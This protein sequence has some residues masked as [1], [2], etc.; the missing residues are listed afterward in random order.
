MART[1]P[2]AP[3]LRIA[4]GMSQGGRSYQEDNLQTQRLAAADEAVLLALADGMGGHAGGAAAS[5]LA[6]ERFQAVAGGAA[7]AS[8][9]TILSAD[10]LFEG[11]KAAN[12]AIGAKVAKGEGPAGMGCTLV[13]VRVD[14]RGLRWISVGDSLLWVWSPTRGLRRLNAD[15]SMAPLIDKMVSQGMISAADAEADPQRHALRS[16]LTGEDITLI[17]ENACDWGDDRV[18]LV[19]SDGVLTLDAPK[20]A[21]LC[22]A[23]ASDP[24]ALVDALLAA[25]A[26][27]GDPDQD[28]TS[29]IALVRGEGAAARSSRTHRIEGAERAGPNIPRRIAVA[30]VVLAAVVAAALAG[31][32]VMRGLHPQGPA[33]AP[34]P[35]ASFPP[36][37]PL[38][39]SPGTPAN[40]TA[41]PPSRD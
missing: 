18:V 25:V 4:T 36:P 39:A 31:L 3:R 32:L 7:V 29:I 33:S 35:A 17:D 6:V 15:H 1:A 26:A 30:G 12:E 9:D 22:T 24:Q 37:R 5:A 11:L 8:D 34:R 21:A 16:A 20:V 41:A 19:A 10:R 28:N 40:L 23:H 14:Q 13:G 38:P 27:A 2:P